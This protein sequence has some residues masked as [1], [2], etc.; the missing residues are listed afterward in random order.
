MINNTTVAV[1][2]GAA[3]SLTPTLVTAVLISFN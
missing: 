3:G 2:F 1:L